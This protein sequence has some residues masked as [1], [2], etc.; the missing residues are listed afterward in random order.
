MIDKHTKAAEEVMDLL[1]T[2]PILGGAVRLLGDIDP[3]G[4]ALF[5]KTL[6]MILFVMMELKGEENEPR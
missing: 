4:L 2:T 3:K 6:R 5:E 1:K